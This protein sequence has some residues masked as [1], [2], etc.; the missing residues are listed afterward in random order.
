MKAAIAGE[1]DA[2]V[3]APQNETSIARAGITFD[4]HPCSSR[5]QTGT[6]ENNVY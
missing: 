1:V 4:G 2:V 6:D 3:A 5:A